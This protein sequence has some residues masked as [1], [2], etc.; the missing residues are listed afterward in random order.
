MGGEDESA[1]G[2]AN[3]SSGPGKQGPAAFQD[4]LRP[5]S[6]AAT[7]SLVD[8]RDE[9]ALFEAV[10]AIRGDVREVLRLLREEEDDEEEEES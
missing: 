3:L 9:Q 6:R 4:I 2:S 5:S 8:A 7:L 10:F 1:T